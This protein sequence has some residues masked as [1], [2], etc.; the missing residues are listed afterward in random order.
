MPSVTHETIF[1]V[2]QVMKKWKAAGV[3]VMARCW[4]SS[5][6]VSHFH[7]HPDE[8]VEAVLH[9]LNSVGLAKQDASQK[10]VRSGKVSSTRK[11]NKHCEL[12]F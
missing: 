4:E 6:H 11:Q 8:Y 7:R 12:K 10:V 9:F 3:P 5:P 1:V 2:F